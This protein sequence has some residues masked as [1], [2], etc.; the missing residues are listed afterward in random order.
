MGSIPLC[1]FESEL[2]S[3]MK[4]RVRPATALTR[5]RLLEVTVPMPQ[6]SFKLFMEPLKD[7]DAPGLVR[8][9]DG[10]ILPTKSGATCD[11]FNDIITRP[12][13][14]DRLFQ[15]VRA[16]LPKGPWPKP[17][18]GAWRRG[19]GCGKLNLPLGVHKKGRKGESFSMV[20]GKTII[21]YL[22]PKR[23]RAMPVMTLRFFCL[24]INHLGEF[25]WPAKFTDRSRALLKKLARQKNQAMLDSPEY[26][27]HP[28]M[29]KAL[30]DT[31]SRDRYLALEGA[32]KD[33]DLRL[34]APANLP[35]PRPGQL[36][37]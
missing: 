1:W 24:T 22:V 32:A 10:E 15:L 31:T 17:G 21:E 11:R 12:M 26:P 18:K 37:Q 9:A 27:I 16:D 5:R 6:E 35:P 29:R 3:G 36:R 2:Y 25:V 30:T 13:V 8:G 20:A 4:L 34:G 19:H 14:T 7:G 23:W 33:T 28:E